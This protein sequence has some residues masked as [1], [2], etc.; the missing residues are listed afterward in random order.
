MTISFD[1]N[2]SLFIRE[3]YITCAIRKCTD[4][5]KSKKKIGRMQ[6]RQMMTD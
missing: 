2:S 3:R 6:Q 5:A 1:W 4:V